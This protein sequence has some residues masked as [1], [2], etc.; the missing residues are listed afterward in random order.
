VVGLFTA[1]ACSVAAAQPSG[2]VTAAAAAFQQAQQAQLTRDFSRAADLFELADRTAPS[3]AALRSAIR[4]HR[5]A[6][7]LAR[8]ATL[9]LQA[10]ERDVADT[11]SVA[12]AAEVQTELAPKLVWVRVTC[13]SACGLAVDGLTEDGERR[14][15]HMFYVDPGR[16][17]LT[18]SFAGRPSLQQELRGAA[19]DRL[20][21]VLESPEPV[22][23]PAAAVEVP[24][25]PV[26]DAPRTGRDVLGQPATTPDARSS[27]VVAQP[28]SRGGLS[29][30]YFVAG[31]GLTA[32]SGLVWLWSGLDTL[33]ARDEYVRDPTEARFLAGRELERRTNALAVTTAVLTA[34]STA[35]ALFTRWG[36]AEAAAAPQVTLSVGSGFAGVSL[37]GSF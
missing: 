7:H 20:E 27:A 11:A 29:P 12:L 22:G 28:P 30:W 6:G 31:A 32:A 17:A 8:A 19:G 35:L 26:A 16:H 15:Q 36:P 2:D 18:A 25:G 10:A 24:P 34:A 9:A 4:N 33:R 23:A 37:A 1:A 13:A 14:L 5:A 3:A 21:R